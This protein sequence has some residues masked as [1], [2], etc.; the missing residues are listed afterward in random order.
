MIELL[1][2]DHVANRCGSCEQ[3]YDGLVKLSVGSVNQ[4]QSIPLCS[5]CLEDLRLLLGK[6]SITPEWRQRAADAHQDAVDSSVVDVD[7]NVRGLREL[8]EELTGKDD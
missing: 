1:P 4:R 8:Q 3:R 5:T 2:S 6:R 7:A